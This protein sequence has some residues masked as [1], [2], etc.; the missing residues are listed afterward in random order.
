MGVARGLSALVVLAAMGI[1]VTA[2]GAADPRAARLEVVDPPDA[3][4]PLDIREVDTQ[5]NATALRFTVITRHRWKTRALAGRGYFVIHL[6]PRSGQRYYVLLRSGD[7][8]MAG[9][10]F[11][12]RGGRDARVATLRAWRSDRT[13]VSVRVDSGALGLAS[14]ATLA[15]RAQTLFTARACKLVCFDRA[16]DAGDAV[17]TLAP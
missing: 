2:S 15:W 10:L 16:P 14:G 6:D 3:K 1:G 9:L 7:G 12:K 17:E 5:S 11:R 4:G 13:S 8:K